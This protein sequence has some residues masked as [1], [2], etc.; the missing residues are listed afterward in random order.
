MIARG[1]HCH[2]WSS[3]GTTL[4]LVLAGLVDACRAADQASNATFTD[5]FAY[6]RA[7]GTIDAPD[8][9]YTGPR[10][11]PS[12]ARGLQKA[13]AAPPDGPLEPFLESSFWRCMDGKVYACSI[14]ANLPCQE[15][16]DTSRTPSSGVKEFC[17]ANSD[18][19]VPMYVTGRA[20]VYE[21][22][23]ANGQPEIVR[24]VTE[25]DARGF[26]ANVWY[27]LAPP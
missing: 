6:C 4:L 20:T 8:A 23:C 24:R 25:V 18:V 22:R 2:W 19:V 11:P 3:A 13:F 10:V 27:A 26:L 17:R 14:G 15:K 21:W 12:V 9:R 7:V 1:Q 5:P 16:A